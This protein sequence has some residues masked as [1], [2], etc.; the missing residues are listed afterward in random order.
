MGEGQKGADEN[1]TSDD[2]RPPT[3]SAARRFRRN[4][5]H[6]TQ[7]AA[8]VWDQRPHRTTKPPQHVR[9][10]R[11]TREVLPN[12]RSSDYDL[13]DDQAVPGM[14]TAANQT[15]TYRYRALQLRSSCL[16]GLGL[17]A[18]NPLE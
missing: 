10:S 16:A 2:R 7:R 15:T 12:A 5:K 1:P 14:Q 18:S 6:H 9:E 11:I 8:Q 3:A 4:R 17:D 13:R